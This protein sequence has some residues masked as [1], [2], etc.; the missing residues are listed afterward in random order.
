MLTYRTDELPLSNI[1]AMWD[2]SSKS[3]NEILRGTYQYSTTNK[4]ISR[5]TEQ[6]NGSN[7]VYAS[8]NK[9]WYDANDLVIAN[10]AKFWDAT[11]SAIESEDSTYYF[12]RIKSNGIADVNRSKNLQ[13]YPNPSQGTVNLV[14][15]NQRPAVWIEVYNALGEK[16]MTEQR[17]ETI[18]IPQSAKGLYYMKVFDGK[19][20]YIE[21]IIIQ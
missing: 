8:Q 7:W 10:T 9:N 5:T 3:W 19:E 6:N 4:L 12:I 18:V 14:L 16:V 11:G 17:T 2:A 20:T 13:I 21:K 15:N 1:F